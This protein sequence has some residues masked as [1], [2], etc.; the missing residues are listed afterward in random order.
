VFQNYYPFSHK[1]TNVSFDFLPNV[2]SSIRYL[3]ED[4]SDNWRSFDG[5]EDEYIDDDNDERS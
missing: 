3:S 5:K 1:S 4:C 2:F